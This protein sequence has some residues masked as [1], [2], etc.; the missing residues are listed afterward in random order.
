[1]MMVFAIGFFCFVATTKT[2]FLKIL[3]IVYDR[4]NDL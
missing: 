3:H 2:P 1:L 4:D